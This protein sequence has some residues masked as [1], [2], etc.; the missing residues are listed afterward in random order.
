MRSSDLRSHLEPRSEHNIY[1]N[2]H[3]ITNFF[4]IKIKCY[5]KASPEEETEVR[6]INNES[7]IFFDVDDTLVMWGT[8]MHEHEDCIV[9]V[10][11][12][13]QSLIHLRPHQPHI[14]LLK[15]HHARG[16]YITVWSAGGFQWAEAVIKAL[17]LEGFVDVVM[18][19]P[20]AYVDDLTASEVLGERIYLDPN[21]TW[22]QQTE[23]TK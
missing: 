1:C 6:I 21:S 19:K 20:R 9:V 5:E 22:G 12:Y 13:D 17:Q 14:K 10:D 2:S 18:S 11:P 3:S 4:K 16:S 23:G 7:N 8:A 15:N